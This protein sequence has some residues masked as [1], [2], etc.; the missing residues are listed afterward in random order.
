MK[1]CHD[2]V[3]GRNAARLNLLVLLISQKAREQS[4]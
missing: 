1:H 4:E 2:S 3:R